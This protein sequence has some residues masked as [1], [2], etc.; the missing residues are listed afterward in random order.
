M[1]LGWN[2]N[3]QPV[4]PTAMPAP[5]TSELKYRAGCPLALLV[6]AIFVAA[7]DAL[8]YERSFTTGDWLYFGISTG[9]PF[10]LL[11]L[12]RT[13]DPVSWL[14]AMVSTALLW[15]CFS[16]ADPRSTDFVW[17]FAM[18]IGPFVI[19][20]ICV[21]IAGARGRIAWAL[22]GQDRSP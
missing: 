18:V 13:R 22:E 10:G 2:E 3:A 20:L 1:S 12:V 7:L 6:T 4:K 16:R 11:A 8:L 17:G 14:I 5:S 21:A 15:A 19:G 9:M